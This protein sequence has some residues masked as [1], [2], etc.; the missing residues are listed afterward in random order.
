MRRL[1]FVLA[2]LCLVAG[3]PRSALALEL[4]GRLMQGG[5]VVGTAAPGSKVTLDGKP[6]AVTP[7]GR[8]VIGF[9]RDHSASALLV[10]TGPD[11]ATATE[12]LAIA[13]R[14]YEIQ[15]IDGLPPGKVGGFDEETLARIRRDNAQVAAARAMNTAGAHFLDGFIWPVQG[16]ISGVYGSQRILNGEPRQPHFGI[17]IAAPTGTPVVAPV[18]GTVTLA[19]RDH[20]FTGGIVIVDHGMGVSS[21]LFHLN[22]VDVTVGQEVARGERIGSVGATGRATGPHL[23]WRINWFDERLDPRLVAGPM[24]D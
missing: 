2:A 3:A 14:E 19:A 23:D 7:D 20:F 5:M 22:T 21:T 13:A 12:A 11:G 16:R 6:V 15:R 10:V 17:D 9:G 8:F 24:P 1:A 4:D 18:A